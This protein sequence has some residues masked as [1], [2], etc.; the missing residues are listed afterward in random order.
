[1][2]WFKTI[3][4]WWAEVDSNHRRRSRRIYSPL[5]LAALQSTLKKNGAGG[6][7]RTNNRLITSQML[8]HWAT[9]AYKILSIK[10]KIGA[11]GRNRTTDTGIFSPLL[12]HLSYR[13]KC[14][15]FLRKISKNYWRPETGSNRRP[16]A[17]QAGALTNWAT[18]PNKF[19]LVNKIFGGPS[20]TWTKDQPVMSRSL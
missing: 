9:P 13:G 6:R 3:T 5:H 17:W 18:G 11:A 4:I 8:Y 2:L 1:M 20:W 7:N 10:L 15:Y 19:G 16:P 12:Y 14:S